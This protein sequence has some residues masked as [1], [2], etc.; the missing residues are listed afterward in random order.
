MTFCGIDVAGTVATSEVVAL[1][2][3]T[4]VGGITVVDVADCCA[5]AALIFIFFPSAAC[6]TGEEEQAD[7]EINVS[8]ISRLRSKVR[9]GKC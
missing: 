2:T 8:K 5:V 9:P 6:F 7:K 3:V 4:V 1:G